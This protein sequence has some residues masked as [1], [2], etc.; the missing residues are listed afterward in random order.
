MRD[1]YCDD[2]YYANLI[3]E[4]RS[5]SEKNLNPSQI[6]RMSSLRKINVCVLPSRSAR[7]LLS[8][9]LAAYSKGETRL[10]LQQQ[11]DTYCKVLLESE[12]CFQDFGSRSSANDVN[13]V[14]DSVSFPTIAF[15]SAFLDSKEQIGK[16]AQCIPPGYDTLV[17]RVMAQYQPGRPVHDK[18]RKKSVHGPL[19]KLLDAP[20]GKQQ[21]LIHK[22]LDNWETYLERDNRWPSH[23]RPTF[24]GYWCYEAAAIVCAFDIDDSEFIDHRYY[25]TDLMNWRKAQ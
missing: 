17:D 19:L 24:D 14:A 21:A 9:V 7:T 1:S 10:Q 8:I 11:F 22:Y 6:E 20:P 16:L 25:P 2:E 18:L 3:S 23:H 4:L 12:A 5:S 15:A 13:L